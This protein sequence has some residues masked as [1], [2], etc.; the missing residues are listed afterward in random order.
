M[1][2][3]AM[4]FSSLAHGEINYHAL[5]ITATQFHCQSTAKLHT[6]STEEIS[7]ISDTFY[8]KITCKYIENQHINANLIKVITYYVFFSLYQ[9]KL[10]PRTMAKCIHESLA[11][12][13]I[14]WRSRVQVDS[15]DSFTGKI[16]LISLI[17]L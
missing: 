5:T 11:R 3:I 14:G 9:S 15:G 17:I 12:I 13:Y 10:L 2:F 4:S 6:L 16:Y 7:G 8:L 1:A